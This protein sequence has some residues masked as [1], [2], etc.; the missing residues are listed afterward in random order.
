MDNNNEDNRSF[1]ISN[2]KPQTT[3]SSAG[4]VFRMP[5]DVS[6]TTTVLM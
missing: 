2:H 3:H 1:K 4:R 6:R 5:Y